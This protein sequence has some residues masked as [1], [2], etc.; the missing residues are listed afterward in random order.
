LG[1]IGLWFVQQVRQ[2]EA[3]RTVQISLDSVEVTNMELTGATLVIRLRIYNPNSITATLDRANYDLWGNGNDLGNGAIS[4]RTDIPP[5][6]TRTI[7]TNFELS[8]AGAAGVIW[9]A[10]NVGKV[11]WRLTGTAFFDTPLG[12]M[13]VPFDVTLGE[14]IFT[15]VDRLTWRLA[16]TSICV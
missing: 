15:S 13:S 10:L 1:T 8:F 5:A 16:Q 4:E 9:S 3:L 7:A 2:R 6:S 11:S 12:T 14:T